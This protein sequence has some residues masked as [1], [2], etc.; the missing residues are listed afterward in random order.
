MTPPLLEVRGLHKA[1]GS[2]RVLAGVDL[3]LAEGESLVVIGGSG[4]G[5]S[6]LIR[7]ILGLDTPDAGTVLWRGRPLDAGTRP[8][9]LDRF[10]LLFQGGALFDSLTVWQNV[11]FRLHAALGDRAARD[12]AIERLARVGL[13][14]EVADLH[15]AALSGGMQKR[16][17]LARAIAADPEL[18]FLDEP[19]TG[20]DPLRAARITALIRGIVGDS[21]A[22]AVTI[23]HDMASA[24]VM[25]DRIAL[26]QDGRIVWDGAPAGLEDAA[27]RVPGLDAF[28]H[29]EAALA[30][31]TLHR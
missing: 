19:T 17:A 29:P 24:R 30:A 22:A 6:V 18:I 14:P 16:A 5:K 13:S 2:K 12:A 8:A 23:T 20:L 1:F 31:E 28:L 9:F 7:C 10:G 11:A 27:T 26:L 25:A 3:T 21:G 15:P 4:T